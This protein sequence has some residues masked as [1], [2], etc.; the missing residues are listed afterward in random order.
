MLEER[1]AAALTGPDTDLIALDMV[2]E[3]L[4]PLGWILWDALHGAATTDRG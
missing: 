4:R 2:A 1:R 3:E